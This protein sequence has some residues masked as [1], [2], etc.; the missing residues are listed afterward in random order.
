MKSNIHKNLN[1]REAKVIHIGNCNKDRCFNLTFIKYLN[2][3][4]AKVIL[5]G[6][7]NKESRYLN[8]TF[9]KTSIIERQKS[10]LLVT[11]TKTGT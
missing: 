10:F 6:N 8:L 2:Y 4:E 9:I 3:R 5:I 1:Y 11:V 7:Y